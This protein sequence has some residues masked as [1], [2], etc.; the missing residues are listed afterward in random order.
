MPADREAGERQARDR[1]LVFRA[2]VMHRSTALP[3]S[4]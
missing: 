2:D 1:E 3:V 4:R